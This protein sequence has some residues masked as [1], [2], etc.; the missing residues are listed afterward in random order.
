MIGGKG[1][2]RTRIN[3]VSTDFFT[4]RDWDTSS[5]E[6]FTDADVRS[7]RKVAVL[8]ATVAKKLFPGSDPIG[9]Q[10]Q[11]GQVPFTVVGV[12]RGEGRRRRRW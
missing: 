8:G 9:A 6:I 4:I 2:W 1:N 12:L 11:I 5:G 3:G 7:G 10:M